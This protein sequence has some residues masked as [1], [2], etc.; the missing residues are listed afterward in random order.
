MRFLSFLKGIL[1]K[2]SSKKEK[3]K[4][5][6]RVKELRDQAIKNAEKTTVNT[7]KNIGVRLASVAANPTALLGVLGGLKTISLLSKLWSWFVHKLNQLFNIVTSLATNF[8]KT[9]LSAAFTIGK[10]SLATVG[11]SAPTVISTTIGSIIIAT[12]V[13][14]TGYAGY[15]MLIGDDI[16]YKQTTCTTQNASNAVNLNTSDISKITGDWTTP[17]NEKYETARKTWEYWKNKGFSGIGISG[18][19]GNSGVESWGF[20]Y[21]V[22]QVKGDDPNNPA[23]IVGDIGTHGYG[24]YQ[25]SPGSKYGKWSGYDGTNSVENQSDYIW[26]EYGG[27]GLQNGLKNAPMYIKRIHN[28]KDIPEAVRA[29]YQAVENNTPTVAMESERNMYANQAYA[30]FGGDKVEGDENRL[31]NASLISTA[32]TNSATATKL[33]DVNCGKKSGEV[34]GNI[35]SVAKSL[36]GYFSYEN[37]HGTKYVSNRD[38]IKTLSDVKKDGVTDC[39]GFVW[40]VLKLAG[41]KVPADMGWYTGSMEK[42]AT[43]PQTYLKKISLSEARAGDIVIVN[44]NGTSGAGANG[45]TLILTSDPTGINNEMDLLKSNVSVIQEGGGSHGGVNESTMRDS[46]SQS[47]W[48][49]SSVIVARATEKV[50]E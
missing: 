32:M 29:F 14:T 28:A 10:I 18:I 23:S 5:K 15:N 1:F 24:L 3:N 42:D 20:I 2:N 21:N 49:N 11:V 6:N 12:V 9:F 26:N 4:Q 37:L 33:N 17:G 41:Y 13:G 8:L 19:L 25:V 43:G 16:N 7:A 40:L 27:A 39:S 36:L 30:L 46:F 44:M 34:D 50:S 45:H 35:V 48:N 22:V 31:L 47:W 38:D